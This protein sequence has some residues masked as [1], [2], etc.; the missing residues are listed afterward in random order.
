MNDYQVDRQAFLYGDCWV[1]A[2]ALNRMFGF[3]LAF[4]VYWPEDEPDTPFED[5]CWDHVFV[6]T[7]DGDPLDIEGYANLRKWRE[8]PE[9]YVRGFHLTQDPGELDALMGELLD[10]CGNPLDGERYYEVPVLPAIVRLAIRCPWAF[11]RMPLLT[12][13]DL[14]E[15]LGRS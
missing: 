7:H 2:L 14:P 4:A 11:K 6:E 1:L 8:A 9:G 5:W 10:N 12:L 15:S 13:D 3:T